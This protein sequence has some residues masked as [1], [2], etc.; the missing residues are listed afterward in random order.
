MESSSTHTTKQKSRACDSC[1][2]RKVKCDNVKPSCSECVKFSTQCTYIVAATPKKITRRRP[3]RSAVLEKRVNELEGILRQA[4]QS[5]EA[6]TS[7]QTSGGTTIQELSALSNPAKILSP[8]GSA[9]PAAANDSHI[10]YAE[11]P[12]NNEDLVEWIPRPFRPASRSQ[13]SHMRHKNPKE[14]SEFIAL[15]RVYFNTFNRIVTLF[16][17]DDFLTRFSELDMDQIRADAALWTATNVICALALRQETVASL[18][19]APCDQEHEAW[20]YLDTAL[21]KAVELTVRG[22]NDLVAIQALLGM[23]IFLQASPDAHPASTLL[24]AA[25]RLVLQNGLHIQNNEHPSAHSGVEAFRLMVQRSRVF[26]IA[27]YLDHDLAIRL[28][29]PP[30]IHEDD[31]GVDLPPLY[32]EDGLGYI[33]STD[34]SIKINFMRVR[35]HLALIENRI[36]RRLTSAR[37]RRQTAVERQTA[38]QELEVELNNW[39][40]SSPDLSFTLDYLST[41]RTLA[42]LHYHVTALI[43]LVA[44]A[45]QNPL[46][47]ESLADIQLVLP[48]VEMLRR[49]EETSKDSNI[50]YANKI[51]AQLVHEYARRALFDQSALAGIQNEVCALSENVG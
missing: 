38:I 26:W 45:A 7:N 41:N 16:D 32:P 20:Q 27:Y 2:K 8:L 22:S 36:H 35:A 29:R 50:E 47:E 12:L 39:K 5:H 14:R 9:S 13:R 3:K 25:I 34:D 44:H 17:Q 49:F 23:A 11:A 48:V 28:E 21:D 19:D 43:V 42:A 40:A 15:I 10:S 18:V 51:A 46:T 31:I 4:L 30:L 6:A 33:S 37:A 1:H 24:A